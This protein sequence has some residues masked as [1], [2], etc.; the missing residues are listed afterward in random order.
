[1]TGAAECGKLRLERAHLRAQD[2]L[3]MIQHAR[4][5][6]IDRAAQPATLR[7]DIDERNH[8]QIGALIH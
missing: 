1:M 5:R 3:A 7:G 4:D 8:G 6:R 2:E